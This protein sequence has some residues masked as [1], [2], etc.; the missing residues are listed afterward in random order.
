[1]QQVTII[2]TD[3]LTKLHQSI[4]ELKKLIE[5]VAKEKIK[6]EPERPKSLS[7]DWI[8]YTDAYKILGINKQKWNR[9][10]K[11]VL[12]YRVFGKDK[13]IHKP[14]LD[15]WMIENAIN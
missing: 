14:S 11:H 12:K 13:W 7:F 10:Y 9:T 2:D 4:D 5:S 15:K 8:Y 6:K 3:E 1:M